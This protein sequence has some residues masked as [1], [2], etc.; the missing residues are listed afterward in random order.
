MDMHVFMMGLLT[1]IAGYSSE[2]TPWKAGSLHTLKPRPTMS[3]SQGMCVLNL[4]TYNVIAGGALTT[5]G[6]ICGV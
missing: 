6:T 1:K 3:N 2:R 4:N 5:S